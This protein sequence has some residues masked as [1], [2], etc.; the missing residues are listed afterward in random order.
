MIKW[1]SINRD[2]PHKFLILSYLFFYIQNML[3]YRKI[4]SSKN[5]DYIVN[6]VTLYEFN[7]I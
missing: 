5:N 2:L 7:Y 4:D 3:L 6:L 1:K